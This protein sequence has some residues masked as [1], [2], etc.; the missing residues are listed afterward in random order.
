MAILHFIHK[1]PF[2]ETMKTL[3][4]GRRPGDSNLLCPWF[5]KYY[6]SSRLSISFMAKKYRMA[7]NIS[8]W[9]KIFQPAL[10]HN[11][12]MQTNRNHAKVIARRK[13][14]NQIVAKQ[15]FV[16]WRF[17]FL[18]L[19]S[20]QKKKP[21]VFKINMVRLQPILFRS[22]PSASVSALPICLVTAQIKK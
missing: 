2:T 12:I 6:L 16:P 20:C 18:I 10:S 19:H 1:I 21:L 8:E 4:T 7:W 22:Q 14:L 13:L 17:F 3:Y 11:L 15:L 5:V 9:F